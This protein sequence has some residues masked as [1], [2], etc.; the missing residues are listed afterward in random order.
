ME[1]RVKL[2]QKVL[3]LREKGTSVAE[4]AKQLNITITKV[5]FLITEDKEKKEASLCQNLPL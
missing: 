2:M 1:D 5:K 3:T 4:I